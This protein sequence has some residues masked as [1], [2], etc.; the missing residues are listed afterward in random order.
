V[1]ALEEEEEEEE[2]FW[3]IMIIPKYL[4]HYQYLYCDYI[5]HSDLKT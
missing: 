3:F 5:L 2:E 1:V 4:N